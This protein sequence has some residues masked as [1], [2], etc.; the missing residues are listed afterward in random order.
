MDKDIASVLIQLFWKLLSIQAKLLRDQI[1]WLGVNLKY[2]L[3]YQVDGRIYGEQ[4]STQ[5]FD[6]TAIL[7]SNGQI[8]L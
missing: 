6:E 5:I 4:T 1:G 2:F 3:I 7:L 8:W